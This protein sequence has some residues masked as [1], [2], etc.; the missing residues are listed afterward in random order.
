MVTVLRT[1]I[2]I[3]DDFAEDGVRLLDVDFTPLSDKF[4]GSKKD[5]SGL[6]INKKNYLFS[7]SI[8]GKQRKNQMI[9]SALSVVHCR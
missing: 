9:L 4:L 1:L 5:V 8:G 2:T 7:A 3:Y 6:A